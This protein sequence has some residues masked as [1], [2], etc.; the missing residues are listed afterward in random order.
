[1]QTGRLQ[2]GRLQTGRGHPSPGR[3]QPAGR[4]GT[5]GPGRRRTRLIALGLAAAGAG[6]LPW[7]AYLAVSLPPHPVAW[8]WPAAWVG[9]DGMEAASLAEHR[10]PDAAPGRTVLPDRDGH[11]GAAGRRRLVRR[12]DRAAARSSQLISLLMAAAA[13]VPAAV[14]CGW[15]AGPAPAPVPR[16]QPPPSRSAQPV[17]SAPCEYYSSARGGREHALARSLSRDPSVTELHAAPGNPGIAEVAELHPITPTD[18]GQVTALATRE[19]RR[20]GRGRPGR[21]GERR[22]PRCMIR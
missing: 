15:L 4:P 18:P 20:P 14:L 17:G 6:M 7:L 9:L 16:Q 5:T 3:D 22:H 11:R 10:H 2:T 8:H 13:E 21:S 1:M 12:D 19:R